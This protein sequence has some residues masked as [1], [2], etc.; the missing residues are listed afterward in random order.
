MDA[1]DWEA[2]NRRDYHDEHSKSVC[3]A[4]CLSPQAVEPG[5]F[6]MVF[7]CSEEVKLAVERAVDES[8]LSLDIKVNPHIF[9]TQKPS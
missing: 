3:M 4:E 8:G 7:V 5:R 9:V 2:M 6:F 1:I